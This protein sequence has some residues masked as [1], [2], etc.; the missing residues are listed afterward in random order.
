MSVYYFLATNDKDFP[1]LLSPKK[2]RSDGTA[3]NVFSCIEDLYELEIIKEQEYSYKDIPYYTKLPYAYAIDW[4][5]TEERCRQLFEHIKANAKSKYKY[6]V[7]QIWLANCISK[8]T[9][10]KDIEKGLSS[11]KTPSFSLDA[12]T[13]EAISFLM[14]AFANGEFMRI[15]LYRY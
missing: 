9:F 12:D 7:Y 1:N 13:E 15:T 14:E 5:C 2:H 4:Q 10:Q 3:L 6:E 11:V 8:S